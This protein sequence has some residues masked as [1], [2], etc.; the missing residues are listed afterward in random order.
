MPIYEYRCAKCDNR[1][2]QLVN[3]MSGDAKV[4]CPECGGKKV[5]KLLSVFAARDGGLN[6]ASTPPGCGQCSEAGS[7]PMR[8]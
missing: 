7:C 2:E 8:Q 4:I 5:E 3:S 1:F 6:S